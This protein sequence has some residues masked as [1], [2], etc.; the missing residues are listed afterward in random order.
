MDEDRAGT[1]SDVQ[2]SELHTGHAGP[3]NADVPTGHRLRLRQRFRQLGSDALPDY[4]LLELLLFSSMPRR[5]TKPVAKALL[6]RFGSFGGV[7]GAPE[8]RLCEVKG[9]GPQTAAALKVTAAAAARMLKGEIEHR[10]LLTAWR[11]VIDYCRLTIGYEPREQFRVLFLDK[12][13]VL[14]ADEQLSKGTVDHTPVYPR[15]V[16]A[17]ALELSASAIILVHNHPSGDPSPS[18]SDIEMT[19]SIIDVA[20]SMGITVHDHVII[21]HGRHASFKSLGLL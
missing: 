17:R 6:R 7:L 20:T 18:H 8:A 19:R 15:E 13:N 5:D 14:I 10:P 11:Q 1:F 16:V 12:K 2:G 9:V 4:E 3:E 21:G